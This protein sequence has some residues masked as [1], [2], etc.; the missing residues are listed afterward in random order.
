MPVPPADVRR[1]ARNALERRER[2]GRGG[3]EVGVARARDLAN[4]RNIS[5]STLRR[6]ASYFA[7][8][9]GQDASSAPRDSAANIAWGLWGGSAGQAWVRSELAK[10]DRERNGD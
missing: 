9:G 4:G 6:M 3:T 10:I 5:E 1:T 7:R 2:H 8:H